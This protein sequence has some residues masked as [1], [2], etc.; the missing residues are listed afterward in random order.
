MITTTSRLEDKKPSKLILPP[1]DMLET[2]PC[3]RDVDYIT[4]DLAVSSVSESTPNVV[5]SG[6]DWLFDIYTLTR[7]MN[8][9]PN[10]AGTQSNGFASTK[11]S[12]NAD[13][14][15]SHD[16]GSKP[17][18]DDGKKV[19]E[20][21]RKDSK[22][23]YHDK[24]DNINRT[25]NVNTAGNV[26]TVSSTVK[27]AGTYEVNVVGGKTSI[28]LPFDPNMPALEDYSIFDFSIDDE[29]DGTVADMN[30]LDTTIQ[31]SP[32]PT[33]RI[34]KDHPLDQVIGD[35]QSATQ[36]RKMS[37][38]LEEHGFDKGIDYDEFFSPIARTEAIRLFL[39]YA[40]FKDFMVYKMDVKSAFLYGKIEEVVYVCQPPGFKDLDF[41]DRVYMVEKA[42]FQKGK[43]DKT[44]FI[45]RH[46]GDILLVQV[47]VDAIIFGP[48]KKELCIAFEKLMHEKFQMSSMGELTFF[49]GLQVKQK[50]DGIFISQDKYVEEILKKFGFTDVKTASTPMETQKPLLKDKDGEEVDVH[51]YRSMIGSLMYLTS[52]RPDIMFVVCACA[53]Y[54]VDPKVSHLHAVKR[55]FRYLKGQPKLGL[56]Y[57]KDSHFDLVAYTNSDYARASLDRKS[58]TGGLF[59]LNQEKHLLTVVVTSRYPTTNNQLRNSSN[60]RQQATINDGRVTLQPIQGRQT[61]FAAGTTRTYT[62]GASGSNSGKQRTVICYNCKGEGHM[63]KQCTKPKRKWHDSWF[64]DKVL[65]VQAQ[66][67]GQILHDEELAFLADPGTA[68][69][70]TQTYA[71]VETEI[72]SDSNIIPYSQYVIESQQ[73]TVQNSNLSAQQDALILSFSKSFLSEESS[74]VG[75]KLYDGNV[76]KNTSAIMI[77]DSEETLMLAEKSRSKILLKQKDH[78][79]LEKKNSV[80]SPEPTLSSRPTKVEVPKE[81][82]KVS[83]VNTSLKKLKYHLAGFDVVVKERTTAI[84]IT[85]GSWGFEL[86]KACFRDEKI[87]FVKALK[88]L[89]N[90]F[91]Q[92]LID[93]L[94]E[95]QNVFLQM[96][97]AVEQYRLK[98]KKKVNT[99]PVDYANSMNSSDPT[100]SSRP[101]KVE[102]PKELPKASMVNTSLKKLKH[103]LAG[104]DVVVKEI[105]TAIAITE[106]SWGSQRC[107][108]GHIRKKA[109]VDDAITKHTIDSDTLKIDVEPITPKLLNKKTAHSAYIKHTQEEAAVLRDLVEHV[110]SNYPLDHSLEFACRYTKLIQDL[111]IN[112]SKTCLSIN[113]SGE[114]L[115]A[116]TPKNKD[117]KV[118]FTEP[119]ISSGNTNTK[120]TS[121]SNLVYNKPMLSSIGV[122]PSNSA[123]G[124]QPSGNTKK[125]KIQRTPSSTTKNKLEAHSRTV[126][127]SLKNKNSVVEPKGNANVQHSKLNAN[128]KLLCVKCNGCMLYDNHDLPTGRTF[129]IVGNACPLTRITTTAEVPLRKPIPLESDTPKLVVTFVYSRKPRKPKTNVP[130]S[131]SKVIQIVLLYLNS[132]FSKHMTGDSSQLTNF[133]NKFL[134]TIKFE[135]D[136]VAKILGYGDYQI[137]NVTISR[138]YYVKGHGY[139]L[140]SI[141]QFCDSNLEVAFRQH[142]CFIRNLEGVD[143][144]IR[145][146]GNNLYTLSF[147]DM[148]ASSP[149]SRHGLVRGLP[150]LKFEKD[151]LCSACAMGKSKK[152][153]HKPKSEDTNQEK[154][155]L[156]YMDLCRPMRVASVNEKKYIL[157][158]YSRFTWVKCIRSKDEA[159][160]FIIKFLKMIQVRLK[161]LVQRIRTDNGTEFVN[162]TLREY[163]K[164]VGISHETSIALYPQQNGVVERRNRTLIKA[165][166]T[167]LIYAKAPLFLW[168]EAVATACYT[169][170]RS[171]I[172]LHH[173]KT[174]YELLHDKLPDLSFF[175]VFCALCYLTN[176]SEN[177]GKLQ[178]KADIDFDELPAMASE[179][180]SS[181]PMLHE[182]TPA[183]ISSGLVPNPPPSTPFVLPSRNN[184]DLL[185]QPLFDELL[186]PPSSVDCPT[187]KVIALIVE[188]VAPEPVASTSSPS[189]TTIDQDAPSPKNNSIASS[190]SDVIPTVVQTAAPNSEHVNKWTKDHPLENIIVEP[191]NYKDTLTQACWIKAM[192]E[193]LHE[194]ER[195]EVWELVPRPDKVM[196]KAR[197][198]ACGYRQEEGIDFE[199]SFA[200]VARLDAIRIFLAYAAHMNMIVY[201]MDVKTT[202]LNGIPHEEVYI[203]QNP[204]GIFINQS[205]YAQESLKKYGMESSDPVD[206]PMVEKS[207][208][209]KDTQGKVVDPTHYRGMNGTF[210]YLIAS[211]P[212]LTFDTSG[213]LHFIKEQVENGVVELYFVN[214]EYQLADI[215]TKSLCRERIE[216]LINKL[217]MQSF[218]PETLKQLADKAKE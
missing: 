26:N 43:I 1:M 133:V 60:P 173:G 148:M 128:S 170:N 162:Q 75:T 53:R 79:M 176:D 35:L 122:N 30:N 171:I 14:K 183:T 197:L 81:L 191:K 143:L 46:K 169:Q 65:L 29:D 66:A 34:Y 179:H 175:H 28:E 216:F 172:H 3:V 147:G 138:V 124:S 129:T 208:Q 118:R 182:M 104:F 107:F 117:K 113:N 132:G 22:S 82:P 80:N 201:Q 6:L 27:A 37:K 56:W 149:I 112:I 166:R 156:L 200:L 95:V 190:T 109:L 158:D 85:E 25:N 187:P 39:A 192:Q 210:M 54:Q 45:K 7:T 67:N 189:S 152:K 181:G 61:S 55:I 94:F 146:R 68:E 19:D 44:L 127:S 184:W 125:D 151:H 69:V 71:L 214:M 142:T 209:D 12:D 213:H 155:Y 131:K 38:N 139:N 102:V 196:N 87:P 211:R 204:R 141:G 161:T 205:K 164:K 178:P 84:T 23:K 99:T 135:N 96:E 13:P 51:M 108:N 50:K 212:N 194:F 40:L 188:V 199:E 57:P 10:V 157:D 121:S 41:P 98:S 11:A 5:G 93:E 103:H 24:E 97:Q 153:P 203:S 154:L 163:Y 89:F 20:D 126:K 48:T 100:P 36:T 174:P 160:D 116:V 15:S 105:T 195:L 59:A 72:T 70:N 86:T 136:H 110:K 130:I 76:I 42:L 92:Y 150:K 165:A 115:V 58:T 77:P 168:A 180:S 8:Y 21:L 123:N 202:F 16:D 47:Y 73:E 9:E 134:G 78:M 114:K 17:S 18:S 91:N 217:G 218:T 52:S 88:D 145:S 144:L 120:T 111:L 177:L 63:S 32:N 215:F 83:M 49:L 167:M 198:V 101:T 206:T 193:E 137:G 106:G 159:P 74:A 207:K 140:F 186:N 2:F 4:R 90:T 185:F 62:P 119:V 64:Q 31:V 33:T